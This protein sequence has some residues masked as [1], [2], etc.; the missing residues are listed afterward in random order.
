MVPPWQA[1]RSRERVSLGVDRVRTQ[2]RLC[3]RQNLPD[4][5]PGGDRACPSELTGEREPERLVASGEC[6][7]VRREGDDKVE[8]LASR[9]GHWW[10]PWLV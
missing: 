3:V 8:V 9:R 2:D 10:A 4:Q 5:S 6:E 7:P 1:G